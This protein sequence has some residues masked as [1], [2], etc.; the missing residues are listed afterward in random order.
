MLQ[1]YQGFAIVFIILMPIN[2]IDLAI[3]ILTGLHTAQSNVLNERDVKCWYLTLEAVA[4]RSKNK[5]N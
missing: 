2:S 3:S 5:S 1:V 4:G